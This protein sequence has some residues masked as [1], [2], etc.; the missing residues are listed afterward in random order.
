MPVITGRDSRR[1]QWAW[2]VLALTQLILSCEKQRHPGP[3]LPNRDPTVGGGDQTSLRSVV[4]SRPRRQ[5]ILK[6]TVRV[7]KGER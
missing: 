7:G 2:P 6:I 1:T 4:H 3:A 5:T